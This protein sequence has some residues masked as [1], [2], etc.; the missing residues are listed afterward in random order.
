MLWVETE[1]PGTFG[2]LSEISRFK[3]FR[4]LCVVAVLRFGACRFEVPRGG[5]ESAGTHRL[6]LIF[7]LLNVSCHGR[8][9]FRY[10]RETD[11]QRVENYYFGQ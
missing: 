11:N 3:L 10:K 8:Q 6:F 7:Y 1:E 9:M 4:T 5:E 2:P